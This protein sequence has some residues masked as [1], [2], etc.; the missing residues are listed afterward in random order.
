MQRIPVTCCLLSL[1]LM[2]L[3]GPA[4]AGK[5]DRQLSAAIQHND[6]HFIARQLA[7]GL[8]VDYR[9]NTET[10]LTIAAR[11]GR[12]GL[13]RM[14][15][16]KGA[17]VNAKSSKG[18][19]PMSYASRFGH[20]R[21]VQYLLNHGAEVNITN[22]NKWTPLLKAARGGHL[23]VVD[24]LLAHDADIGSRNSGGLDALALAR[25]HGHK[26]VMKYLRMYKRNYK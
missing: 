25:R 18:H 24:Y 23:E 6:I 21:I 16:E 8:E 13:V 11:E 9:L 3:S 15:V 12:F 2:P 7:S 4:M 1:C 14:L 20:L 22:N 5:L 10:I 19:N 17:D 26:N